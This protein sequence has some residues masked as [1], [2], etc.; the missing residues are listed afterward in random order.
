MLC[1][2]Q[3]PVEPVLTTAA[4]TQGV[5][6]AALNRWCELRVQ[7]AASALRSSAEAASWVLSTSP[8]SWIARVGR[9][10]SST[11]HL[12]TTKPRVRADGKETSEK[13]RARKI[14]MIS[15]WSQTSTFL[16]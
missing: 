16:V 15:N 9:A 8:E 10:N 6:G 2:G 1:G 3:V 11:R 5:V 12:A 14:I 13:L 4:E 7:C